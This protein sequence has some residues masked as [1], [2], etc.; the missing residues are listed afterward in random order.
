MHIIL[1]RNISSAAHSSSKRR[2]PDGFKVGKILRIKYDIVRD[3]SRTAAT[4]KM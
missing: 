4:S 2:P 3:G 1:K